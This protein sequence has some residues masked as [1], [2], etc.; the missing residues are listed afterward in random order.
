MD[1]STTG[2]VILVAKQWWL[3][4]NTKPIR[5]HSMDGAIFPHII[6][7]QYTVNEKTYFKRKWISAGCPVP[8]VGSTLTVLYHP[9]KPDKAKIL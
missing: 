7:V 4:V 5:M 6:K 3:K 9:E 8:E 2:T 1:Q